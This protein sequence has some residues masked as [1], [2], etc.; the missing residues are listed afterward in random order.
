ME[1]ELAEIT[2]GIWLPATEADFPQVL[3]R[4]TERL[5]ALAD[6]LKAPVLDKAFFPAELITDPDD[7]RM[8]QA[9]LPAPSSVQVR[10]L[11]SLRPA[12]LHLEGSDLAPLIGTNRK[13]WIFIFREPPSQGTLSSKTRTVI[14]P[15]SSR[16]PLMIS[17]RA[18]LS[19]GRRRI[20]ET[21]TSSPIR[22]IR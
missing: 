18:P 17:P 6:F 4:T 15:Y 22:G 12:E 9:A 14:L 5:P 19:S 2:V 13:G 8:R 11:A 7:R 20:P 10:A 3:S 1:V 16:P 21:A